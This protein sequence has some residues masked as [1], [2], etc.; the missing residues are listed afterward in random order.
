MVLPTTLTP[1]LM[2]NVLRRWQD[3]SEPVNLIVIDVGVSA[4]TT[5]D[6]QRAWL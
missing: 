2:E 5:V 6:L 4:D 1:E 3:R